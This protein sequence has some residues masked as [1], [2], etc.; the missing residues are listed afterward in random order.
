VKVG[1]HHPAVILRATGLRVIATSLALLSGSA[2]ASGSEAEELARRVEER[3]RRSRDLVA[4]FTQT[5]RS[6]LLRREVVERGRLSLKKP[7]RMRWDYESPEKKTFV[8]DGRRFYFYVPADRQVIVKEQRDERSLPAQLLEGGEILA[9]FEVALEPAA[10]GF[11][12]LRLSPRREDPE[13]A[14]AFLV[15]DSKDRIRAVEIEDAQGSLSRF[16]F[17]DVRENVGVK[18]DLFEFQVPRG[19]EVVEG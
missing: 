11:S 14:K 8:S 18:D 3:H 7:G 15:I 9:H 6:G 13:I 4:R 19:V 12:R 10:N 16:E 5:Y 17:E 1:Y 2:A